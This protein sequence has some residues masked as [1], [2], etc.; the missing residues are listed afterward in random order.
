MKLFAPADAGA[1]GGRVKPGHDELIVDGGGLAV[2]FAQG[3]AGVGDGLAGLG[4]D[5]RHAE[6][7]VDHR[8]I[9]DINGGDAGAVNAAVYKA[10]KPG[11]I[12]VVLDHVAAEGTGI[13]QTST[14]HRID[15]VAAKAEILAA[16]FQFDGESLVLRRNDDPHTAKSSDLHDHTDQFIYRFRKPK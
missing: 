15:P 7:A 4:Q 10:L 14:L 8:R 16:G 12:Y 1:L 3:G 9:I 5:G 13:T 2:G 6:E 11:G